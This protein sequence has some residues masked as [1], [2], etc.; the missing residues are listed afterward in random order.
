MVNNRLRWLIGG[1][2]ALTLLPFLLLVMYWHPVGTHGFDW[3]SNWGGRYDEVTWLDQQLEWYMT[4]MGRFTSTALLSAT[5]FWYSLSAARLSLALFLLSTPISIAWVIRGLQPR[6]KV[7]TSLVW[8]SLVTAL[9]LGQLS[10]PYDSLYCWSGVFTYHTGLLL[11]LGLAGALLRNR[12]WLSA[13]LAFFAVGTNEIS[14]VQCWG[15]L[16][17]YVFLSSNNW[18]QPDFWG[19]SICLLLGTGIALLAPGNFARL[20]LYPGQISYFSAGLVTVGSSIYLWTGWVGSGLIPLFLIFVWQ[21]KFSIVKLPPARWKFLLGVLVFTV[22]ISIAPVIM[23]TRGAS[24]P[25]GIADWQIIPISLLVF[26]LASAIP[27]RRMP[28]WSQVLVGLALLMPTLFSGLSIDR[29]QDSII[30]SYTERI[31]VTGNAGL[32]WLQLAN[33]TARNYSAAVKNQYEAAQK[34]E[35]DLVIVAPLPRVRSN[36]LYDSSYDRRGRATGEPY[37]GAVIGR[38]TIRVKYRE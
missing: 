26:Y 21:S 17:V 25:E 14:L 4:T 11:T 30:S 8:G 20:Q 15:I 29:S 16:F 1:L 13:L 2:A 23:A 27:K 35:E 22:P 7:G 5:N 9:W 36:F 31:M 34:A 32:A 37:F 12:F 19:V 3:I 38:P 6:I 18:R 33:G 28:V 10:N 24:F